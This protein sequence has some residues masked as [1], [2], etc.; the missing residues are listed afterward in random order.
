M[1]NN[2]LN[3]SLLDF[4]S[5]KHNFKEYLKSQ[6]TFK[7]YNFEG[8]NISVLLDVLSYNSYLN[9]F[10]LNM[11]AS[12]MF[13]D[14]AQKLDSVISHA[15]ELNYLPRS[16]RSA[17]A[18]VNVVVDAVGVINPLIVPKGTIFSGKTSTNSFNFVTD[19][20]HSYFSSN[21]IYEIPNLEIYEGSY[22]Q[23]S[24]IVDYNVET[25]RFLLSNPNVD[26]ESLEVLVNENLGDTIY[27]FTENLSNLT[28]KSTVYFLQATYSQQY[29][30]FFGDNVFGK[31]PKNGSVITVN[32]RVT[33]GSDANGIA[34]IN[35]DT[36]IGPFNKG[37]VS[38]ISVD[39]ISPTIS[40]ANAE[41]IESI[42]YNAPKHYQTQGRCVTTNDYI[43][44]V[45][46]EYPE[47]QYVNVYG[48]SITNSA[49]E[50]GT[51]Y[52]SPSTY[53]GHTLSETRKLDIRSYIGGL[54]PIGTKVSVVDP[55]YLYVN[56]SILLH[57]NFR[58][59]TISPASLVSNCIQSV[60]DYNLNNLQNFNT[61]F[62]LSK[63]EQAI[64][65]TDVGIL[66][67]ETTTTIYKS[68]SPPL[69]IITAV[70]CVF[71]NKIIKGSVKSSN[72]DS[73][74]KTYIL[75]DS[76]SGIDVGTGK[77]YLFEQ[78]TNATTPNYSLIGSVDY[79]NGIINVDHVI[80]HN[81]NGGLNI[82]AT[83]V[84]QDIYCYKNTIIEI[85]TITGL[86][87]KVISE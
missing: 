1:A 87:F 18:V 37:L 57:V 85:D 12:E 67:N 28:G 40:G 60:K 35:M 11:I 31:K 8:S 19:K 3:V 34:S 22:A 17:K 41:S 86:T 72:F 59:T 64:N 62:R 75:T 82:T 38:V 24:F 74:G 48:G 46:R 78:N 45:L 51:V 66:S 77:L 4:D 42:R 33:S 71:D 5:I 26:T 36:D 53:A 9:S 15:K 54:S 55:D 2:S 29:E 43:S 21:T 63:V 49:V 7:D 79:D 70:Y 6:P 47:I 44:T 84:N 73:L 13:L 56:M 69:D 61:A 14:S 16:S 30:I 58:N 52:I 50:Y 27:T 23:D 25:Q 76:I 65:E 39:T 83:P 80:Y 32:Y 10:Y 68:F 20:Q 81:I